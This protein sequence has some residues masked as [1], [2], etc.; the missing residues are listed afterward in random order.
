[1][2]PATRGMGGSVEI[3]GTMREGRGIH[4]YMCDR[5]LY[6]GLGDETVYVFVLVREER[7]ET[8]SG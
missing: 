8:L 6:V 5:V 2:G 7:K 3:M 1:M 4:A